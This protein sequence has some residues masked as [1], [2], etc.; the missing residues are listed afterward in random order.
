MGYRIRAGRAFR[1]LL[2]H[3]LVYS[4]ALPLVIPSVSFAPL[5]YILRPRSLASHLTLPA[6]QASKYD[7]SIIEY[8]KTDPEIID[9]CALP[10][11][12]S[13]QAAAHTHTHTMCRLCRHLHT[14]TF[15]WLH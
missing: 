14:P 10:R 12:Q 15:T 3:A 2:I 8:A 4:L 13:L 5:P 1:A 7:K 6:F 11:F 9:V